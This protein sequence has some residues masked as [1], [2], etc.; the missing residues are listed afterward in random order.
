MAPARSW[1]RA[2]CSSSP[3]DAGSADDCSLG[4]LRSP[5]LFISRTP[6]YGKTESVQKVEL[7]VSIDHTLIVSDVVAILVAQADPGGA[8]RTRT[9]GLRDSASA[10]LSSTWLIRVATSTR[11]RR[12]SSR[13]NR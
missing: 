2:C 9:P 5:G 6:G 13:P 1:A 4:G 3:A 8:A 12:A 10:R 7:L 11:S